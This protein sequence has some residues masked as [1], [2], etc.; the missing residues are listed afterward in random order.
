M[1]VSSLPRNSSRRRR[2]SGVNGGRCQSGLEQGGLVCLVCLDGE[3]DVP[4][5]LVVTTT[6]SPTAPRSTTHSSFPTLRLP[7]IGVTLA[8]LSQG[9][10]R[11]LTQAYQ[12]QLRGIS[13]N[14]PGLLP[15]TFAPVLANL[16]QVIG[17]GKI[18]NWSLSMETPR[19]MLYQLDRSQFERLAVDEPGIP[20]MAVAQLNVQRRIRPQ[21]A[22]LIRD[23]MYPTLEDHLSVCI[24]PDVVGMHKECVLARPLQHGGHFRRRW[25]PGITQQRM[26]GGDDD[27][28][29]GSPSCTPGRI[30]S[31]D[32]AVLTPY[33]GQL[34]KLRA[35]LSREFDIALSDMGAEKLAKD[36]FE[37]DDIP[38]LQRRQLLKSLRLATVDNF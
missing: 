13:V 35:A 28:G 18:S 6:N 17:V 25:P 5:L 34:Q 2:P 31:T 36:G 11:W 29:A 4:L 33:N 14:L 1:C 15:A 10:L 32:I 8:S 27:P 19:G 30:Q 26:G 7:T 21:I 9:N 37:E 38:K 24:L 23:T 12:A 22:S 20:A 3:R 16:Q